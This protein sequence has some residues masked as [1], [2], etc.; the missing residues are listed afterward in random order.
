MKI[1]IEYVP[2]DDVMRGARDTG[3]TVRIGD[4]YAEQLTFD[5]MLGTI[6]SLTIQQMAGDTLPA[7]W[8]CQQWLKTAEQWKAEEEH[9]AARRAER[10]LPPL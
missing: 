9:R 2:Y 4:R 8:P 1:E 3:W 5:E 10:G 7:K 6:A